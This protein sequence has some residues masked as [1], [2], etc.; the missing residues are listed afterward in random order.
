MKTNT[1][2]ALFVVFF[3]G[4]IIYTI[5][6]LAFS[7]EYAL[8]S[9]SPPNYFVNIILIFLLFLPISSLPKKLFLP[10][11]YLILSVYI[12]IYV[13]AV[14]VPPY[15]I[16][17]N[18]FNNNYYIFLL[19]F[20]LSIKYILSPKY[21][22]L[23]NMA[24]SLTK[25]IRKSQFTI[26]FLLFYLVSIAFFLYTFGYR[27]NVP[28]LSEVYDVRFSYRANT[29]AI[30]SYLV[31]WMGSVINIFFYLRSII[32]KNISG[33]LLTAIFQIYLFNIM[34]LKTH[35]GILIIST[36]IILFFIRR[37]IITRNLF[38]KYSLFALIFI[39]LV[40]IIIGGPI[41]ILDSLITRRI[42][43]LPSQGGYY[44]F[45]FFDENIK[46]YWAHTLIGITDYNYSLPP[47]N[48]IGKM[49][50]NA[51]ERTIV[52]NSFMEGFTAFGYFGVFLAGALVKFISNSL[53][54][55]FIYR[56]DSINKKTIL[57]FS[58]LISLII[59]SS[60]I[61]T[62]LLS[63]GV[64]ILLLM[65]VLIPNLKTKHYAEDIRRA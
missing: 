44:H 17:H 43:V 46:T 25:P 6:S 55:L 65:Y 54:Y 47:P 49:I 4:V 38:I 61:L 53:D 14:I 29:N 50:F 2:T 51:P 26:L 62:L 32:L 39:K 36:L 37:E 16:E 48:L 15:I 12:L 60:G 34:A 18:Y 28:S 33:V 8:I 40:D 42:F 31:L 20:C 21:K 41:P 56:L 57:T 30:T 64:F 52:V 13:P 35:I 11:H 27:F 19:C 23:K 5:K 3:S 22:R 9:Y 45:D 1:L 63:H 59:N 7:F 10:S 24:I 58:L